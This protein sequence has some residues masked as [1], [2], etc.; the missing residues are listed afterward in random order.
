MPAP[1]QQ[2]P[3]AAASN[4]PRDEWTTTNKKKKQKQS[5]AKK[6]KATKAATPTPGEEETV[7]GASKSPSLPPPLRED[8]LGLF[9]FASSGGSGGGSGEGGGGGSGGGS[10]G[11]NDDGNG[12]DRGWEKQRD[13]S[14]ASEPKPEHEV[15]APAAEKA[16]ETAPKKK[17]QEQEQAQQQQRAKREKTNADDDESCL[18]TLEDTDEEK[19]DLAVIVVAEGPG[20]RLLRRRGSFILHA[21]LGGCKAG[22]GGSSSSPPPRVAVHN[23]AS[24][25]ISNGDDGGDKSH[26]LVVCLPSLVNASK[27]TA[28]MS[29]GGGIAVSMPFMAG[30]AGQET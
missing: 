21:R 4:A 5:K 8:A 11:S 3:E 20:F 15:T 30:G 10:G 14:V 22:D 13:S 23:S 25:V 17:E 28:S 6:T 1:R 16:A 18:V 12:V 9:A 27:V 7:R 26:S 29:R 24:V 19:G 2:P